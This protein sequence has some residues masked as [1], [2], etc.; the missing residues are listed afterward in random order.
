ML[1][2][3]QSVVDYGTSL[4]S[5]NKALFDYAYGEGRLLEHVNLM[6]NLPDYLTNYR[7]HLNNWP[8]FLNKEKANEL[9]DATIK[10]A[11]LIAK[12]IKQLKD[13]E[14]LNA[15]YYGQPKDWFERSLD[16]EIAANLCGRAD[17]YHDGEFFKVLELN[18]GTNIG[19]VDV[20]HYVPQ[21]FELPAL[22][23]FFSKHK[24]FE[25]I[26]GYTMLIINALKQMEK[27][28]LSDRDDEY[29]LVIRDDY[30]KPE[31]AQM[32]AK[33]YENLA[34]QLGYKLNVFVIQDENLL[35]EQDGWVV[36]NGKRV[37]YLIWSRFDDNLTFSS[38][39]ECVREA[40]FNGRLLLPENLFNTV[41]ADKRNLALLHKYKYATCFDDADRSIIENNI[42]WGCLTNMEIV[43][44]KGERLLLKTL[45]Q[46]NKDNF[47]VKKCD[48]MQ[49][50]DVYVGKFLN[51][52]A[53][54]NAIEAL[55]G[56]PDYLVQAFV[57][58]RNLYFQ[59]GEKGISEFTPVWGSFFGATTYAG[60]WMRLMPNLKDTNGVINS[61]QGAQET[62]VF[63][64]L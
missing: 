59:Y 13:V 32:F 42:P 63:H 41:I 52:E 43:E 55:I 30:A 10:P 33:G 58:P 54:L 8:L 19:G 16:T 37:G 7:Y 60:A 50:N 4:S 61:A 49:G 15:E 9:A 18:M 20:V 14:G 5:L 47:V 12:M 6:G 38:Y 46:N 56:R 35:T 36:L 40:Y 45:L 64:E 24:N 21:Y 17:S 1:E 26:N 3:N 51:N 62:I 48:G 25:F 11:L 23:D 39:P 57:E 53:W 34:I 22:K 27:F 31:L 28:K 2:I 44:Y 29:T